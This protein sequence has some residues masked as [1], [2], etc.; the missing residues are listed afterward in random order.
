MLKKLAQKLAISFRSEC[1]PQ[2]KLSE[3]MNEKK[4]GKLLFVGDGLN[5]APAM[6]GADVGVSMKGEGNE[7]TTGNADIILLRNNLKCVPYLLELAK[8]TNSI[9]IQNVMCGIFFVFFGVLLAATGVL[10]PAYAAVF[11]LLD[12][13]FIVFNSARLIKVDI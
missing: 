2:D 3:I 5:D 1:L 4:N 7:V 10:T 13:I 11:H 8:K 12:A 9:I 6:A